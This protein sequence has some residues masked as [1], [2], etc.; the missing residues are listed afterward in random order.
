MTWLNHVPADVLRTCLYLT[1]HS[2]LWLNDVY[3]EVHGLAESGVF[4]RSSSYTRAC[5]A[6]RPARSKSA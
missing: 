3:R 2:S 5:T 1:R 6:R 4:L